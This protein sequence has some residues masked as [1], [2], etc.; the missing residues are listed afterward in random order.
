MSSHPLASDAS[1]Y[2]HALGLGLLAAA[3]IAA[4]GAVIVVRCLTPLSATHP[5]QRRS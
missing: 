4:L 5:T 1:A 3:A 2:T